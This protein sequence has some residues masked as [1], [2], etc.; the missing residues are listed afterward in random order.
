RRLMDEQ[1]KLT[2]LLRLKRYERPDPGFA[3]EFLAGF[4]EYQRRQLN[5]QSAPALWWER[6]ATSFELLR[7]PWMTPVAAGAY[8]L[9]ILLI[10]VWPA[11]PRGSADTPLAGNSPATVAS[12]LAQQTADYTLPVGFRPDPPQSIPGPLLVSAGDCTFQRLIGSARL[13]HSSE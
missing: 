13:R 3:G 8:A 12:G 2:A 10:A 1:E 9:G 7:R 5:R 11:S 6:L 4:H